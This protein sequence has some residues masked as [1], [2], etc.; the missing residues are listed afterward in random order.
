MRNR[1]VARSTIVGIIILIALTVAVKRSWGTEAPGC[2]NQHYRPRLAQCCPKFL[3][4]E[5]L[6]PKCTHALADGFLQACCTT[7]PTPHATATPVA[8]CPEGWACWPTP[9]PTSTYAIV[10]DK[11]SCCAQV[12]DLYQAAKRAAYG[13]YN[14]TVKE[15]RQWRKEEM[16]VAERSTLDEWTTTVRAHLALCSI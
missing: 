15:L 8:T 4:N 14:E 2:G 13:E 12:R 3:A 11:A 10:H 6:P 7:A 5:T 16:G 9:V 1:T